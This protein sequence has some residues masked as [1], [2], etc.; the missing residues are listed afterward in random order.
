LLRDVSDAAA[1]SGAAVVIEMVGGGRVHISASTPAG[2]VS[3]VL[4]ALR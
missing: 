2:L 3:A 4:K 1:M